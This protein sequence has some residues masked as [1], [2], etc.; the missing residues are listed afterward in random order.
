MDSRLWPMFCCTGYRYHQADQDKVFFVSSQ[1]PPCWNLNFP[2]V[3]MLELS[4]SRKQRTQG[5]NQR[6]PSEAKDYYRTTLKIRQTQNSL[7]DPWKYI[8]DGKLKLHVLCVKLN[9][10]LRRD[11]Q[12]LILRQFTFPLQIKLNLEVAY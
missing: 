4:I 7:K 9:S 8:F 1:L 12:V 6:K 3:I 2:M 11:S 5:L 10:L